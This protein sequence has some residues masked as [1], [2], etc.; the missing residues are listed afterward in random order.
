MDL[1][2][3]KIYL[4]KINREYARMSKDPET[5]ARID[6]D[7]ML[8]YVRDLYDAFL[9]EKSPE[10]HIASNIQRKPI[11][12]SPERPQPKPITPPKTIVR[13][14]HARPA[15]PEEAPKPVSPPPAPVV[16]TTTI[17]IVPPTHFKERPTVRIENEPEMPITN[18]EPPK[19]QH[20]NRYNQEL[21]TLFEFKEAKE[22]SEKLSNLPISD[23][24]KGI[25]LNDRLLFQREL[26]AA[27]NNAF[28]STLAS[29]NSFSN[30][31]NAKLYLI[32]HC[33]VRFSWMEKNRVEIAKS[34]I[35][36]VRRRYI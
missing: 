9:S 12:F 34:F 30:F 3:A 8:S 29:L 24:K 7:I 2:K 11:D 1:L 20:T 23:L 36:F 15:P 10:H 6:M 18:Q 33:A 26:F 22:L 4:D 5:I 31:E 27:D 14:E 16:P 13:E 17:E 25:G 35:K 19:P 32:D 28:D 21:E